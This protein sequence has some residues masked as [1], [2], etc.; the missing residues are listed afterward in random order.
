MA[1]QSAARGAVRP[2]HFGAST[3]P[4]TLIGVQ[5]QLCHLSLA[6]NVRQVRA[7][8]QNI[9]ATQSLFQ[10]N[11]FATDASPKARKPKAKTDSA[12]TTSTKKKPLTEKQQEM[13]KRREHKDHIKQ[14]KETAL[15]IPKR[16]SEN[17]YNL[18]IIDKINE[19]KGQYPPVE[20]MKRAAELIKPVPNEAKYRAQAEQNK[21]ANKAAFE[22]WLNSYTP[23]QIRQANNARQQLHRVEDKTRSKRWSPIPDERLVKRA[24][25]SY[26]LYFTERLRSSDNQHM[27]ARERFAT[28][29]KDWA[30]LPETEK[31]TYHKLAVEDS[32]RYQREHQE[33]YGYPVPSKAEDSS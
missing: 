17:Y 30:A 5:N 31:E 21:I 2:L 3:R 28:F 23:L 24:S 11:A 15:E 7:Q 25:T 6:S 14:L 8:F 16:A 26:N 29:A 12:K 33:V 1:W 32:A 9:S 10:S 4:N 27:D 19:I 18:A 20:T 13:R 22:A